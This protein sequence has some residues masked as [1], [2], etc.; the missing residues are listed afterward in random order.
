MTDEDG[1]GLLLDVVHE[2]YETAADWA[3]A[4]ADAKRERD[5]FRARL[6]AAEAKLT[7]TIYGVC[8]GEPHAYTIHWLAA[9]EEAAQRFADV[10]PNEYW[11]ERFTL[12]EWDRV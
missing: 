4:L 5:D 10:F 3:A 12:Y 6:V 9:E 7:R 11:V 2:R 8:S 1:P